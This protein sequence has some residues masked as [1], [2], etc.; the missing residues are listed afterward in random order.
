MVAPLRT[1]DPGQDPLCAALRYF[2]HRDRTDAMIHFTDES[3][4]TPITAELAKRLRE[5]NELYT[6]WAEEPDIVRE[7][8]DGP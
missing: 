2:V 5:V 4:W 1:P 7:V 3:S 8:L 6:L